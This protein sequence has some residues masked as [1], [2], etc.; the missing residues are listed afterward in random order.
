[1]EEIYANYVQELEVVFIPEGGTFSTPAGVLHA[2]INPFD[3][4]VYLTEV[5]TSQ[6]VENASAREKNIIR[7]Y[8]TSM[9]NGVPNWPKWLLEK[10][11][12]ANKH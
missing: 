5:R 11:S 3:H 1:M 9:R 8:D 10:I 7:I 6:V 12:K 2:Y 4:D